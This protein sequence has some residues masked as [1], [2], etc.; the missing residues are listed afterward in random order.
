VTQLGTAGSRAGVDVP[1]GLFRS[2]DEG[3][4]VEGDEGSD[5]DPEPAG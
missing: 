5:L 1:D 3:T 2:E 4:D